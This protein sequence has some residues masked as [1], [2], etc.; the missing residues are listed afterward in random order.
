MEQYLVDSGIAYTIL[1]PAALM[2]NLMM[3]REALVEKGVF[4]QKFFVSEDTRMNLVDLDDVA[5]FH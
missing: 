4:V 3:S 2:Q 5:E 1:Q